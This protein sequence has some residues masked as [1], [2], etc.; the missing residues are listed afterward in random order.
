M[1]FFVNKFPDFQP[2]KLVQTERSKWRDNVVSIVKTVVER[3]PPDQSTCDGGLYVGNS[4]VGYMLYYLA[5]HSDFADQKDSY[6]ESAFMY[7]KVNID[8]MKR[9]GFSR[10]P[11]AAFVLG[12]AGVIALCSLLHKTVGDDENSD[13]YLKQY[14]SLAQACKKID[15]FRNGSD[16]LLVGRAGYLSGILTLQQ[17]LGKEVD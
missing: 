14:A 16:E 15:F 13:A 3:M 4:G 6:L 17:K 11:P 1:R 2:D 7:A 5:N 12:Q 8:Y 9:N 10:D